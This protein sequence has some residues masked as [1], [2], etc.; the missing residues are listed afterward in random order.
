MTRSASDSALSVSA[1]SALIT[2]ILMPNL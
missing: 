2:P 1:S